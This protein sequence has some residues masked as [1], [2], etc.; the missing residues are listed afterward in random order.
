MLVATEDYLTQISP[1]AVKLESLLEQQRSDPSCAVP[2]AYVTG[3][4]GTGK[5]FLMK[6][7]IEAHHVFGLL[8]STT[9]ISAV[10][11]GAAT[12]NSTFKYFDTASLRDS[13]V[14]GRLTHILYRVAE[15]FENIIID[16]ISM[17]DGKQLDIFY[18]AIAEVNEYEGMKQK[19]RK[20]GIIVTGDF[21]QLPPVKSQWAFEAECWPYFREN[22]IRLTKVW[23][24]GDPSFL[25]ALNLLRSG[26]GEDAAD[27][28]RS[29][30]NWLSQ[31]VRDFDGT[32]IMAKN[33]EVDRHNWS[34]LNALPGPVVR[35]KA[36]RVGKQLPEWEKNIPDELQLKIGSY[37]M[38]LTNA[39]MPEGVSFGA[40]LDY[41][42][43][44]VG[45]ARSISQ[46][47]RA[48]NVEII[49]NGESSGDW[50]IGKVIRENAVADVPQF[51]PVLYRNKHKRYVIGTI[52]FEPLRL[53]YASTVHK[54]QGLTLGGK[55]QVD[56]RAHFFGSPA[57]AYVAISRARRPE[58]VYI[59]GTP[60]SFAK[61]VKAAEEVAD[62]L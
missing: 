53:A 20:L 37:V 30:V 29:R 12:V 61:R 3:S 60:E 22:T 13:Y 16:E 31:I 14:R 27:I 18:R 45:H 49:R 51:Q 35:I 10:N 54:V 25:E 59:V 50:G 2:V 7:I 26:R 34:A 33:D 38:L 41:A 1:D 21:L 23:R 28:L 19:G 52:E 5:T 15:V 39:P 55:I 47:G 36:H 32:T 62:Y 44:D 57:M 40:I 56:S 42:N 48:V 17:M 8:C 11:L 6:K 24:Q 43:G 46:V 4:A 58:D 9:G